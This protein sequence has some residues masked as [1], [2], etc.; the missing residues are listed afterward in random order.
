MIGNVAR[1]TGRLAVFAGALMALAGCQDPEATGETPADEAPTEQTAS[2]RGCVT[3]EPSAQ[4]KEGIEALL[5]TRKSQQR[6]VGSVT[7]P[8]Y[9]HVIN[10]GTGL[11]NGDIPASQ[12]AAQIDVLNAAYATT[13]FKFVLQGTDRTTNA[14][15][16]ALKDNSANERAM[17]TALRKGG[18]ETLNIYS[19]NLSGTLLG[20]ATF[21]SSYASNPKQDGVVIRY[22]TVPG[23]TAAPFHLGDTGTHEV[24]HWL[25]LYHTFQ[26]G[27]TGAGDSVSDTPA[28]ASPAYG[29]PTGRNTCA[30]AGNDPITNFMDYTDDACMDSF[31]AG[32]SARADQLT[33]A[34][35]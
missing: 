13:P 8:V 4:E 5:R 34:Y 1:R 27:C 17:K 6:A 32:Q 33:A 29:C 31:T 20:W 12:I 21:P 26:G 22:T 30:S 24:G 35:R 7:V 18:P 23:G 19:A 14:K 28:E 11:A 10:Q 15:W 3:V 25:G 9:F 16:Y 2:L